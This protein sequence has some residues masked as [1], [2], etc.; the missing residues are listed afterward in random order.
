MSSGC[1]TKTVLCLHFQYFLPK[2]NIFYFL[3][4]PYWLTWTSNTMWKKKWWEKTSLHCT[5][6]QWESSEFLT[7]KYAVSCT[8]FVVI[9]K[10]KKF[11][12]VPRLLRVLFGQPSVIMGSGFCRMLFCIHSYMIM[13]FFFFSLDVIGYIIDFR[14]LNQF[15]IPGI[16]S[17][18][19]SRILFTLFWIHFA[20]ILLKIFM[21]DTGL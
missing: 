7:I 6:V 14:M 4:F 3:S 5:W 13:W 18:S 10:L 11:T 12:S 17:W 21:R 15:C 8:C 20:K 16:N 2:G 19:W 1:L 9:I